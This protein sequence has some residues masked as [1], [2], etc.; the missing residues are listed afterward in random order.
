MNRE[1]QSS[2]LTQETTSCHNNV[3]GN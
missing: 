2:F 1:Q 3:N